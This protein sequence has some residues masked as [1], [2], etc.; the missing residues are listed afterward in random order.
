MA[1]PALSV[2]LTG[3]SGAGKS[4]LATEAA[5]AL[6]RDGTPVEVL[7][8]DTLRGNLWPELGLSREDRERNLHRIASIAVLLARNGVVV[9]IAAIAPYA[10]ARGWMRRL[11]E[12]AGSGFV[13]VHVATPVEVCRRRDVKGLYAKQARGQLTGL[14]GVDAVYERPTSAELVLDTSAEPVDGCTGRLVD[15]VLRRKTRT[16]GAVG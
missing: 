12:R 3:L 1:E 8:G 5:T 4:T 16:T 15:L 6:R 9:L 11:H 2:L 7:D 14:T 13:E 10:G